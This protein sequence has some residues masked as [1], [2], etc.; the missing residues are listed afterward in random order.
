MWK[1][2]GEGLTFL[3]R[4][5]EG[6]RKGDGEEAIVKEKVASLSLEMV[7]DQVEAQNISKIF[8]HIHMPGYVIVNYRTPTI[9]EDIKAT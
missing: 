1:I 7:E 5:L 8:K 4:V 2:E 6:K 9:R 3:I